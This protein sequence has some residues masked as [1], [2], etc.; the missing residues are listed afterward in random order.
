MNVDAHEHIK[1]HIE[2]HTHTDTHTQPCISGFSIIMHKD[3]ANILK[4]ESNVDETP[5]IAV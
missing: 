2:A 3:P 4:I 5:Q 1:T